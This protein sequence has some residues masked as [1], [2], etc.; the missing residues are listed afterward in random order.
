MA[1]KFVVED[2]DVCNDIH[3]LA[4][5]VYHKAPAKFKNEK[6]FKKFYKKLVKTVEKFVNKRI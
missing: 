2:N 4:I 5:D 6:N 1:K 3:D